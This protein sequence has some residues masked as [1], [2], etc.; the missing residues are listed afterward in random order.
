MWR[1]RRQD[2]QKIYKNK[3]NLSPHVFP[4]FQRRTQKDYPSTD[5]P[6]RKTV[7]EE[8]NHDHRHPR[9]PGDRKDNAGQSSSERIAKQRL[10]RRLFFHRRFL[11]LRKSKDSAAQEISP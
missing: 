11:S 8:P 5:R 9:R 6:L 7:Q 4:F 2:C 10:P 3:N 1:K